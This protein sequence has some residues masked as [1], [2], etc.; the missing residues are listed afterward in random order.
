VIES[1]ITQSEFV[2]Q[3]V[4]IGDRRKFVSA[5][6]VPDFE[7]LRAWAKEK[8]IET[9]DKQRLIEDRATIELIRNEV[10]RLTRELADYEK[11]K[12]IG[13][14]AREFTIDGGELT[15]TLKI[16]RRAVEDKYSSLIES[17]YEGI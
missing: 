11:V 2:E 6:I 7:R 17:F 15:P 4:V 3:A 5:L 8:G 9:A 13:L 14:L 10:Q 1:L 12:R 16:R